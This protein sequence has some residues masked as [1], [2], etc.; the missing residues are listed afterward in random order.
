MESDTVHLR[1]LEE[2]YRIADFAIELPPGLLSTP[3]GARILTEGFGVQGVQGVIVDPE[4]GA[5][6]PAAEV[7]IRQRP[8]SVVVTGETDSRGFFRLQTPIPGGFLLSARALGYAELVE[9]PVDVTLGKLSVVEIEMAPAALALAP[10]IVTAEPR[11]FH[12][13][14]QGFYE[15]R[16]K[17]LDT[18]IFMPPELLE[19]RMPHKLTDLFF[20]I[21]GTRVVETTTG[22]RGIYFRSGERFQETCWP[23]VFLDRHL[24]S[25]G[26]F[27][28]AGGEPAAIDDLVSA[29]DV[30]AVEV[31]RSPAE[32]PPAFNGPNA[33]CGVIVLWT[34]RGGGQ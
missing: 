26:G 20:E 7:R 27:L 33:G 21:P 23:M 28:A 4:S 24:I 25:P 11:A 6:I 16:D 15:R 3:V 14:M 19:E 8:G 29:F 10:I 17:G 1:F 34:K 22:G 13:E 12:L 30:S 18:G 2:G 5:P 32:I 9:R 31:Y